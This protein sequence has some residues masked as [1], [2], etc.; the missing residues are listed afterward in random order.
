[1]L[2]LLAGCGE[3]E[4]SGPPS[5]DDIV[6]AGTTLLAAGDIAQ[7]ESEGDEATARLAASIPAAR[8][9]ALGDTAYPDAS[10]ADFE[11]C[12]EPSWGPV[13]HRVWPAV[14]NHEY[15]TAGAE[16]F[17][18]HFGARAGPRGRGCHSYDLGPWHVV[19]LN[20]NCDEAPGGGCASGSEQERWLRADL[21]EH[22]GRAC[23]LA[24]MH[25]P[26]RSSGKHGGQPQVEPLRRTLA[27]GGADILLAAH[28]H[29]YERF[30]PRD[31]VREWV[32]GTG[33]AE[34]YPVG[35]PV[36]GSRAR[37]GDSHGLLALALEERGYSWR[38]LT[39]ADDAG[40]TD[41]GRGSCG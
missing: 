9:A 23:T 14:G 12:Y 15:H 31:G 10:A 2:A 40:F 18:D 5:R 37:H 1:M 25:H 34:R 21:R 7:C 6:G 11:R 20:S 16:G 27:D 24:Y 3:S 33:G 8:I 26:P 35:D 29:H 36:E 30:E 17:W 38:Y 41:A 39:T 28:D 4:E 32:V 22:R 13:D 19:V